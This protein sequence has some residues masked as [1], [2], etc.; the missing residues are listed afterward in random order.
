MFSGEKKL[1]Q[2]LSIL[3]LFPAFMHADLKATLDI[4]SMEKQKRYDEASSNL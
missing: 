3:K 1:S 4:L 2:N